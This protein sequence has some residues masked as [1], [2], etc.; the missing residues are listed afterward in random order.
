LARRQ[1]DGFVRD[2]DGEAVLKTINAGGFSYAPATSSSECEIFFTRL[3]KTG[4]AIYRAQRANRSQPFG[5]AVRISA[6]AGFVEGPTI[7]PDGK[8]LYY[9]KRENGRFV[10]YR[11]TRL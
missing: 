8:S 6:I 7:S 3:D 1:G 11:V 5:P 4:P 2:P 10:L 9:H